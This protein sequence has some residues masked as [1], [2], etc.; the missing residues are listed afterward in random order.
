ML[1][2]EEEAAPQQNTDVV[3]YETKAAN[4]EEDKI[5]PDDDYV[6]EFIPTEEIK[7]AFGSEELAKEHWTAMF[8]RYEG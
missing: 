2:F 8:D 1:N 4:F 6:L 7:A 3:R 5:V